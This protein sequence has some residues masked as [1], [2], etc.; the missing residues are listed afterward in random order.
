MRRYGKISAVL[1]GCLTLGL[2]M[3][4]C[5]ILPTE[6][7][8]DAA[9]LVKQYEGNNYS[10]YTV[11]R[12]DMIERES[13]SVT[14]QGT[15]IVEITGADDGSRIK[16]IKVKK[17]S[18]VKQ[19][20]VLIQEYVEEDEASLKE[21]KREIANL[22]L[23]I[24]QA[25]KM[26]A[27][28]LEQLK[29][30]GGSRE[31]KKNVRQQYDSQIRNYQSTLELTKLDMKELQESIAEAVITSEV[32]GTVTKADHSYEDDYATGEDVLVVVQGKK[33][34]RFVCNSEYAKRYKDG[35]TVLVTVAGNQ[36]KTTAKKGGKNVV[37]F[38]P[39]NKAS[40]K[41]GASGSVDLILKE[42][43]DVIYLPKALVFE[44]GNK[45]VVYMEGKSG[46]KEMREVQVG[47]TI[48]NY[49]EITSGLK[50][51]EQVI[52]N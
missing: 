45:K 29:N 17:G 33:R 15:K 48:Q 9:P 22:Q 10:K 31:E 4:G 39:K 16:A 42:K 25:K 34:N 50:E 40:L 3:S 36:Y 44:M 8:F 23:Q 41:N 51:G 11:T 6:E 7:E 20:S 14:Y 52:A 46:V 26:K 24:R 38:Y 30:T 35:D 2:T 21:A 19:G 47:E 32:A 28:E 18:K 49:I 5:A 43:K 27:R 12:G 37:Y 1:V 13:L